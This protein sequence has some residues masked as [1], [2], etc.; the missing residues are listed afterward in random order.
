MNR[1]I[2]AFALPVLAI[3]LTGVPSFS[4][5][6]PDNHAYKQHTEWKPGA[7]IAK[8]DWNRGD[9]VDFKAHHLRKPTE[10]HEWRMVDGH[11]VMASQDGHIVSVRPAPHNN[12]LKSPDEH[13][14]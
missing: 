8:E 12:H 11:Y 1:M 7:T 6:H 2:K 13:P 4:Q 9:K 10:G 14:Q 5:D 3:A